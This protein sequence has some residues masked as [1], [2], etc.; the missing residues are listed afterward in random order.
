MRVGQ[1][2]NGQYPAKFPLQ[3]PS[4]TVSVDSSTWLVF[5]NYFQASFPL[6]LG[7][8]STPVV[9]CA[10]R[11]FVLLLLSY[12]TLRKVLVIDFIMCTNQILYISVLSIFQL[13]PIY[14]VN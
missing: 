10:V 12:S 5:K 8:V 2:E 1:D 4:T 11:G 14:D 6:S 9:E 13:G 7:A 3:S